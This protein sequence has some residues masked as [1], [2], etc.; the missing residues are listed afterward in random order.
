M[1]ARE[2][3]Y[4][5]QTGQK[6]GNNKAIFALM[7][8]TPLFL[9]LAVVSV[10][11]LLYS[12]W[13]SFTDFRLSRPNDISFVGLANYAATFVN[14]EFLNAL[15]NS[16]IYAVVAVPIEMVFGLGI[17]IALNKILVLRDF[18]RTL[19]VIP[20][21]LAPV[22][23]GLMWKFMFNDQI[24]IIN[25][26][27]RDWGWLK[28][29]LPWLTDSS[30]AMVSLIIVEVWA[31]TPFMVILLG[32]GLTTISAELYEAARIDG[33]TSWQC[34]V[35]I[36]L[37]MLS[38]IILVALLIRGMDAFRVFDVV[39]TLTAGGPA[40]ATD[41]LSYYLYRETFINLDAGLS[42][43]GSFLMLGVLMMAGIF[44]IRGLRKDD[45]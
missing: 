16:L 18:A 35:K 17:A 5:K 29:P 41:V 38:P 28:G 3:A 12:V 8:L 11:P 9:I 6:R 43:A 1:S 21:M 37:P 27:L 20:M 42:A 34:F 13:T 24:G 19:I 39:F 25:H 15:K 22:V 44:L 33:A 4:Q 32:A 10:Y 30:L 23:M 26:V 40:R 14:P 7:L 2:L 31:T 45:A 36:T